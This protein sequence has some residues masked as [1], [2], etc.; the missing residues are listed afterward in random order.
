MATPSPK[1]RTR[2]LASAGYGGVLIFEPVIGQAQGSGLSLPSRSSPVYT[3]RTPGS[4]RAASASILVMRACAC[5]LRKTAIVA[6][7]ARWT[8]S[9]KVPLPVISLGSS[10]RLIAAPNALVGGAT[11]IVVAPL[12]Y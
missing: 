1:Y 10:R 11:A 2:P 3:A 8:S 6:A 4:L 12:S 5:G 9:V 7:L